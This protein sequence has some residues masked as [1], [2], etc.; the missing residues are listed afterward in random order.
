MIIQPRK[1]TTIGFP[2]YKV[3]DV[4]KVVYAVIVYAEG[5]VVCGTDVPI[6]IAL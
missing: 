1:P 6:N 5:L 2:A 4:G 3:R